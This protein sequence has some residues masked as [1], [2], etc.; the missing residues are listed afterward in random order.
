MRTDEPKSWETYEQV[1]RY[2]LEQ[3]CD[4]FGLERVEGKQKLDGQSGTEWE[5]DAKGVKA[6]SDEIVVVECRRYTSSKL[7]QE[8]VGAFAYRIR[9]VGATGGIVVTPIGV[10]EG[11]E[12]LAQ[13]EGIEVVRLNAEA[14][15]TDYILKFLDKVHIGA[16]VK[17]QI[18]PSLTA[19]AEVVPAPTPPPPAPTE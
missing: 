12:V 10:Q 13:Y 16:S 15:T 4:E 1:A 5:I 11:G 6:D 17:L 3:M 7:K 18:T 19:T 2:L 9:D 14:T 8:D